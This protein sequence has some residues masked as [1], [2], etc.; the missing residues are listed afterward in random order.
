MATFFGPV[1]IIIL[2]TLAIYVCAGVVVFR[3]RDQLIANNHVDEQELGPVET[4]RRVST[5]E[6]DLGV[7]VASPDDNHLDMESQEQTKHH[8]GPGARHQEHSPRFQSSSSNRPTT[9]QANRAAL[10][11]CKMAVMFFIALF[12]TWLPSSINLVYTL[13]HPNSVI[14][15]L[16]IASALFLPLQGFWNA[17]VYIAASFPACRALFRFRFRFEGGILMAKLKAFSRGEADG[18]REIRRGWLRRRTESMENLTDARR[19][20]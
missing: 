20:K 2:V 19:Q 4:I 17:V 16:D 8:L 12:A 9:R 13:V 3:W 11:Y 1:W 7:G 5:R 6:D 14:F 10:N 18:E 15:G